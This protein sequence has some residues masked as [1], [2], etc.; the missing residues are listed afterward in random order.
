MAESYAD[1]YAKEL[2]ELRGPD[3]VEDE[4]FSEM[5][6]RPIPWHTASKEKPMRGEM[7]LGYVFDAVP[8]Q[9]VEG[10]VSDRMP[11]SGPIFYEIT[12]GPVAEKHEFMAPGDRKRY[13]ARCAGCDRSSQY[14]SS[15]A[16]NELIFRW[17]RE[18]RCKRRL[19]LNN[20]LR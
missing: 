10:M 8:E 14:Y 3:F 12:L 19:E 5:R 4:R 11:I 2:S 1:R 15:Q 17:A 16:K 18:H 7:L 6:M 9:F 13:A 20:T